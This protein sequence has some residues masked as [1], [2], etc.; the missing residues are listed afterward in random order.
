MFEFG[1][2]EFEFLMVMG[3]FYEIMTYML[4]IDGRGKGWICGGIHHGGNCRITVPTTLPRGHLFFEQRLCLWL[5][6]STRGITHGC[7][8]MRLLV[9][10]NCLTVVLSTFYVLLPVLRIQR[11]D[12]RFMQ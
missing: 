8:A 9:G 7:L 3:V 1:H 10:V 6:S 5:H 4:W 12:N 2:W 11:R